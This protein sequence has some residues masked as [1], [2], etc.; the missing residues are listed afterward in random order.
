MTMTRRVFF[1]TIL[2]RP[3]Q[4]P[5]LRVVVLETFAVD[6]QSMALLVHHAEPI[7]REP[8]AKWLQAH[9]QFRVRVRITTGHDIGATIF[10]VRMCFGRGLIVLERSAQIRERDILSVFL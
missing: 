6:G 4:S 2:A 9:S 1:S 10:R 8:F 3:A 5:A 7:E